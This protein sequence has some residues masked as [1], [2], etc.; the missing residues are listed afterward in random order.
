MKKIRVKLGQNGYYIHIGAD[1]LAETGHLLKE[2]GFNGRAVIITDPTV[3]NLYGISLRQSLTG[4][5]FKTALLEVPE[6][7]EYKSLDTAGRLYHELT[8]FGAERLTPILALGGGVIGDIAGF[9]AATYMRGVPLVQL[10]T[11]LLAQVDSSIG[12]KV[13]V[14]HGKLKNEIGAFYQPR[15]V[16]ADITTLQTLPPTELTSGLSEV[17]KYAIIKDKNFFT[18]LEDHLDQIRALD[19]KS[20]EYIVFVSARIKAEIVEKDE[21]DLGLRNILNFGHTIGHAIESVS[22]F[23]ISHGQAVAVGMMMASCIA[24]EIGVLENASVV[25]IRKLLRRAG[26][27][28]KV[29]RVE[30]S[31]VLEAMTHDK[32]V[33]GGKIRFI[34]PRAIGEVFTTDDV[35]MK[36]VEKVW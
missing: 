19:K 36:T 2:L 28:T 16:I 12:G 34:L 30:L 33:S 1:L 13:A 35:N 31:K 14:N 23:R 10:P 17:I 25:R 6:G 20:L 27:M 3:K 8:Q 5:G 29:P 21:K 11:T 15:I 22:E 4:N 24:S 26:L 18:Y 32:K 9:V 7:E